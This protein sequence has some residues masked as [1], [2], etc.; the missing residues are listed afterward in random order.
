MRY[1]HGSFFRFEKS[2]TCWRW[3]L[4][5]WNLHPFRRCD[6]ARLAGSQ[7][8]PRAALNAVVDK[9]WRLAAGVAWIR[10]HPS[11]VGD[12][13]FGVRWGLV[14]TGHCNFFNNRKRLRNVSI[15]CPSNPAIY[16]LIQ[17]PSLQPR[18][19]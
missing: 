2:V 8:Q 18:P 7:G 1:I 13:L 17:Q 4:Y 10:H 15:K 19:R 14:I 11:W 6:V 3:D 9:E 16:I 5:W 12:R